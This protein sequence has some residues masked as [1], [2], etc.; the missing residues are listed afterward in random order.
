MDNEPHKIRYPDM[1]VGHIDGNEITKP[2]YHKVFLFAGTD[3]QITQHECLY[4]GKAAY[5]KLDNHVILAQITLYGNTHQ[6]GKYGNIENTPIVDKINSLP[7]RHLFPNDTKIW[8][9]LTYE[10]FHDL[11]NSQTLYFARIDQ[12]EDNLEGTTPFSNIKYIL[13]NTE[14]NVEQKKETFRLFK[15]RMENNRKVSFACC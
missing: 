1:V 10:K 15:M 14:K 13:A 5:E 9:Y 7:A 6:G 3:S 4:E 11:F 8:R 2:N 12:F